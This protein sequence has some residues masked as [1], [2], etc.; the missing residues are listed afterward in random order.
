MKTAV[1]IPDDVYSQAESMAQRTRL[2]RSGLYTRALREYLEKHDPDA[3]TESW[4]RAVA[5]AGYDELDRAWIDA[6]TQSLS[7]VEWDE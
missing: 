7:D 2:S 5:A 1:S 3:I 6:A 4:N